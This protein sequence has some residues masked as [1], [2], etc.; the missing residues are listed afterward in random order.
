MGSE[1]HSRTRE[2]QR[3]HRTA[4]ARKR[5][6]SVL[7]RHGVASMR[8]LE[9]KISDAGPT[10]QRIDPHLLTLAR[11]EMA[12]VGQLVA[13]KR[14]GMPWYH[15]AET[16]PAEVDRRLD[17]LG[18]VHDQTT[19][20]DFTLRMGQTLEIAIFRALSTGSMYFLGAYPDLE[21][22][23]DSSLYSQEEPPHMFSGKALPGD[24]R[25][26]FLTIHPT[27]GPAGLEA[28]NIREW[29]YPDR[30]EV[31]D[32]LHKCCSIDA[33]PV[34]IAR[35]MSYS[36]FSVLHATGVIVHQNFNQHYPQADAELAVL[37]RDK[38]LLGYHDIR[39]G[40]QPDARLEKF[41]LKDLPALL[42]AARKRFSVYQDLLARYGSGEIRY[43][44]FA[45]RVRQREAGREEDE[46]PEKD[47]KPF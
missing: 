44:E 31:S 38:N 20:P 37:A 6:A 27:A 41:L 14:H 1:S 16:A 42:P 25:L 36:T 19:E 28:K 43:P 2:E 29:L 33:V 15:L 13:Q 11:G 46:P 39:V 23:D 9:Q 21:E 7:R 18:S 5:L 22:H 40:N 32:L 30:D 17:E 12:K 47:W 10:N 4:L 34:L 35:R 45:W 8:T 3:L 24:M 26:D